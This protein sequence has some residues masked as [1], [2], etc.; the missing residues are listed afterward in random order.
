M[1]AKCNQPQSIEKI[2]EIL[3]YIFC[4]GECC[5]FELSFSIDEFTFSILEGTNGFVFDDKYAAIRASSQM[6]TTLEKAKDLQDLMRRTLFSCC[7][8]Q[9]YLTAIA[10]TQLAYR[11]LDGAIEQVETWLFEQLGPKAN[12]LNDKLDELE[13]DFLGKPVKQCE[14]GE[15]AGAAKTMLNSIKLEQ[16]LDFTEWDRILLGFSAPQDAVFDAMLSRKALTPETAV[17]SGKFIHRKP[18]RSITAELKN[19]Q[20]RPIFFPLFED[21]DLVD[22]LAPRTSAWLKRYYV[23]SSIPLY[24]DFEQDTHFEI[25]EIQDAFAEHPI[26]WMLI[27]LGRLREISQNRQ[28]G[29]PWIRLS[30]ERDNEKIIT[31][32]GIYLDGWLAGSFLEL[33]SELLEVLGFRL[34]LPFGKV[35]ST[36]LDTL[37]NTMVRAEILQFTSEGELV[38]DEAYYRTLFEKPRYHDLNKGMK[39]YREKILH[40]LEK[41]LEEIQN[42]E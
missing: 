16:G 22:D 15:I 3:H 38:L 23:F 35:P 19:S 21:E 25:R 1:S 29:L 32:I 33:L 28:A 42:T 37:L 8:Y 27:Q 18:I 13:S 9:D 14:P 11:A 4:F 30:I 36:A 24:A 41:R 17:P 10:A 26:P 7:R 2:Q 34:V 12:A 5:L 31:D 6:L 40:F 20:E 39:L